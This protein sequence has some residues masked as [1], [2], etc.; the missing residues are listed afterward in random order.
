[1]IPC[2]VVAFES[3]DLDPGHDS[4]CVWHTFPDLLVLSE[5]RM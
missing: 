4:F 3:R 1:M 5:E 2:D